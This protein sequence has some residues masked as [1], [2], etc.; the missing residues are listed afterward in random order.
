MSI[1][2]RT[3]PEK[4]FCA[5]DRCSPR[6]RFI[7]AAINQ[8]NRN[9]T[10]EKLRVRVKGAERI[11]TKTFSGAALE[12]LI[13]QGSTSLK[14]KEVVAVEVCDDG[15]TKSPV[16]VIVCMDFSGNKGAT[17]TIRKEVALFSYKT[18]WMDL[19]LSGKWNAV[20]GRNDHHCMGKQ[21]GFDF[22]TPEDMRLHENPEKG[23]ANT[24]HFT[25]LGKPLYAPADGIV[26]ACSS[27]AKDYRRTFK[28]T[29]RKS[30]PTW[31]DMSGNHVVIKTANEQ[32][33][34]LAHM[35]KDS[36]TVRKGDIVSAGDRIGSV[37]NSGNTTGPHLHIEVLDSEP[38]LSR[39]VRDK[40]V[41]PPSGL[42]FGFRKVTRTRN[43]KEKKIVRCVPYSRDQIE[44]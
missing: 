11:Q 17:T 25:S 18:I 10:L 23:K 9:W 12:Q 16:S 42:P 13:M 38:D 39:G 30:D 26:V 19:P 6:W 1:E 43:N 44:K 29:I 2:I 14:R 22:V 32:F 5:T 7:F 36:L 4:V 28:P 34:L 41:T 3:L 37:G 31:G 35:L 20:N 24:D 8:T 27:G 40:D 15:D 33:I 21:F